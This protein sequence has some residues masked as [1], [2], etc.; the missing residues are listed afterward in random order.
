[1]KHQSKLEKVRWLL[2]DLCEKQGFC[3]ALH[4]LE[5]FESLADEG[6]EAFANALL[7]VEGLKP[8]EH[9][10]AHRDV[11]AFVSERFQRWSSDA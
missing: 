5:R 11:F 9:K 10:S 4:E 2:A 1:M 7:I 8:D 3:S 6:A